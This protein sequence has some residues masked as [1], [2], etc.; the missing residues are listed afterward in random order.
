M[1][2]LEEGPVFLYLSHKAVHSDA[3]PAER[4]E[5]Q[6]DDT[7]FTLPETAENTPE[8]REGKCRISEIAGMASTFSTPAIGR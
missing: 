8:N 2:W 1:K 3:V 7:D 4:H 5:G 6:Y